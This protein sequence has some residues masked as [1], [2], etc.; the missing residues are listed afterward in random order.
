M[1]PNLHKN[2]VALPPEP[3]DS[4]PN[5]EGQSASQVSKWCNKGTEVVIRPPMNMELA[6]QS[7]G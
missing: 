5:G 2:C 1:L 4:S 7:R 3:V 6:T